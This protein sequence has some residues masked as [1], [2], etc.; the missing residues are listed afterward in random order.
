M[1][2]YLINFSLNNRMIVIA[3]F[4]LILVYGTYTA[5]NMDVDVFPD[6]TAPT[7]TVFTEAHGM[8]QKK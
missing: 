3:A 4:T 8:Q 5:V 2:N 7:V 1:L 6:L